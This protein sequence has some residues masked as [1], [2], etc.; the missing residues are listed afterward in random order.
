MKHLTDAEIIAK[1]PFIPWQTPLPLADPD[2]HR[3]LYMCELCSERDLQECVKYETTAEVLR[4]IEEVHAKNL[5]DT[6]LQPSQS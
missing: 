6:K 4:H 3:T 2:N 5:C 1:Y